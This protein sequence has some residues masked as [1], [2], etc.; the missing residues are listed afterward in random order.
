MRTL[1]V[2]SIYIKKKKLRSSTDEKVHYFYDLAIVKPLKK[3]AEFLTIKDK[4]DFSIKLD[5]KW[6][7]KKKIK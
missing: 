1:V 3:R 7:K 6:L 2:N 5:K 4:V